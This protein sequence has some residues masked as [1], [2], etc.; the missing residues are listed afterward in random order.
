MLELVAARRA[1]SSARPA[2]ALR[3]PAAARRPRAR[4]SSTGPRC[5]CSTSRSARSTSSCAASCRPQ[6]KRSSSASVGITFVYVT[7]DQEEAFSMSDRVAVMNGGLLEQV[8]TPEDVYRGRARRSSPTSSARPTSSEPSCRLGDGRRALPRRDRRLRRALR[9]RPRRPRRAGRRH[10]RR[11]PG[12]S[13]RRRPPAAQASRRRSSTSRSSARSERCGS[14]PRASA[15]S[16]R[17]RAAR[18]TPSSAARRSPSIGV[19]RTRGPFHVVPKTVGVER[20]DR[21]AGGRA[22]SVFAVG[23]PLPIVGVPKLVERLDR[24]ARRAPAVEPVDHVGRPRESDVAKRRPRPGS[25]RSPRCT[26]ERCASRD[27]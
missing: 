11:P 7:H 1:A 21:V 8:G 24:K 18:V 6:L 27:R 10:H 25:S 12:G 13:P 15:R 22:P 4:R 20:R 26:S 16:W 23:R 9:R 17:R 3:R 5:C 2:P 14:T 19:K